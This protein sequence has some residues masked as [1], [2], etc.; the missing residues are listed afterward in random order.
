MQEDP[1][2]WIKISGFTQ[3]TTYHI[4]YYSED[5][6][7]Y[8]KDLEKVLRD[9]DLSLSTYIPSSIISRINQ[10]KD[11]VETDLYFQT[12]FNAAREVFD[13]SDGVFD[14]TVAPVVN[15][16]G[17]GFTERVKIDELLIDSLLEYVGM[18]K[19]E[20]HENTVRKIKNEIL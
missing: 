10:D 15:A 18:D 12:C 11:R 3:G 8:Q 4:T 17:F 6:T 16:W 1:A 7:N 20:L 2:A 19:I 13:A 5:S 9:F 14:I